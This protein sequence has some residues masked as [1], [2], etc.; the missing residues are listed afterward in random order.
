MRL[1]LRLRRASSGEVAI[2]N[3]LQCFR[4]HHIGES[5]GTI[6]EEVVKEAGILLEKIER[7]TAKLV[8]LFHVTG[9]EVLGVVGE[10]AGLYI[11]AIGGG[12]EM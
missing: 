6:V 12:R 1:R 3:P 7:L 4:V 11:A 10:G 5:S 8:H 9:D 2:A